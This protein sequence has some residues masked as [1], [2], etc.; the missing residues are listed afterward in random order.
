MNS[1]VLVGRLVKDIELN[2]TQNGI[3]NANFIL[4]VDN[5][6]N[7]DG[8]A[9]FIG[10]QAWKGQAEF[11]SRYAHKGDRVC[12]KGRIQTRQYQAQDGTNRYI[13]EVVAEAVESYANKPDNAPQHQK[14]NEE[15]MNNVKKEMTVNGKVY[16]AEADESEDLPF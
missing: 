13:T 10:I 15:V 4:A 1:V 11:L 2:Q 3:A 5:P 6:F 8:N 9:D 16:Q 7:K 14:P 12:V